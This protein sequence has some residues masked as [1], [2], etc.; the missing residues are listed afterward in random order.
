MLRVVVILSTNNLKIVSNRAL[1]RLNI[2]FQ[3]HQEK[4][5]QFQFVVTRTNN[6]YL[7][8][9]NLNWDLHVHCLQMA[10]FQVVDTINIPG[11]GLQSS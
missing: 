7:G 8:I 5:W 11:V 1:T 4:S 2:E 3:Y 10:D 9:K 6:L